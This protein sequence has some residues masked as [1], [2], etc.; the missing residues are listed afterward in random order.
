MTYLK[1]KRAAILATDGF[2]QSEF[3]KPM[4]ALKKAR[5]SVDVVSLKSGKIKGWKKTKWGD[6]FKVDVIVDEASAANYDLLVLPGGVLNSDA[7]RTNESAIKFV[8]DFFDLGKPIAAICHAPWILIET[9]KIKKKRL[10]SYHTLK[11]DLLNAGAHWV[12][13][14]V[15]ADN[16]LITSRCPKDLP[17]F[18]NKMIEELFQEL[19]IIVIEGK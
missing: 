10:T 4:K 2:E 16:K 11:T 14:E 5:V 9:G 8:S 15:V 3:K 17:A 12:D 19:P 1:G 18:C 7:L 13:E 6:K